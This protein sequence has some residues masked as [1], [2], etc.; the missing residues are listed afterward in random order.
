[1]I[2]LWITLGIVV[3]LAFLLWM[4]VKAHLVFDE[5]L[6]LKITYLFLRFQIYPEKPKAEKPP[7]AA[8]RRKEGEGEKEKPQDKK[9]KKKDMLPL[10][11]EIVKDA[12]GALKKALGHLHVY[13]VD[14]RAT[15][16]REDAYET[17][18]GYGQLNG[19]V[20]GALACLRNLLDVRIRALSIVPD[21]TRYEGGDIYKLR[22]K[23]RFRPGVALWL[24][25]QIGWKLLKYMMK[26]QSS[27][28]T[29]QGG[30]VQWQNI[31]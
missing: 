19:I 18:V 24:G 22:L 6:S 25:L 13:D 4:P 7:K 26:Q 30:A 12:G 10:L 29:R 1:M 17:A 23:A 20:Y 27:K 31:P 2:G 21:F 16:I 11:W 14:F 9:E 15:I 5:T 8:K 28:P 3:F